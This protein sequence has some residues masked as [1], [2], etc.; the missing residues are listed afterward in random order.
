MITS[1]AYEGETP[2]FPQGQNEGMG[3]RVSMKYLFCEIYVG[4]LLK[5]VCQCDCLNTWSAVDSFTSNILE[6]NEFVSELF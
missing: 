1:E 4:N 6:V 5:K 2:F 3:G